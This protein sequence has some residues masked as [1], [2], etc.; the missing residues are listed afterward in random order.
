[1][2][3][4]RGPLAL[5]CLASILPAQELPFSVLKPSGPAAIRPYLPQTVPPVRL[6]NSNRLSTLLRAGKLYLTVQDAIALAV[7]NNLGLEINRYGP[8]L[9][10]SALERSQA[11]GPLRG[12]P[13]A[14][15]QV[16]SVN[17][18]V[19]VNGSAQSA[20][21]SSGGGG[22]GSGS[23]GNAAIQQVGAI[24]PN[25]DPVL[26]STTTQAHLTQPQA[27]TVLS[28]TNA[29]IQTVR[30]TNSVLQMGLLTGGTVQFRNYEQSFRENAPS[31]TLNPAVGPHMDLSIRQNLL[32]GFG[33]RLNDR[34]I[35][36][37]MINVTASRESFR[38]QLLDM[39]AAVVNQYWDVAAARN[40]LKTPRRK[41]PPAPCREWSC[42]ARRR[43]SPR[44][45]RT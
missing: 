39:V 26:Q 45:A 28:Q 33:V 27:N 31:D 40:S 38:S 19:G 17:A 7:E 18:G 1:V 9:A 44:A 41:S 37:S 35:R 12:V 21:L 2:R 16:S 43:R 10:Q 24:T 8:L 15:A 30:T 11:G 14:S 29:L 6:Y 20:G 3:S 23:S 22:G 42:P 13:S 34:S 36:I 32:Q 4:L 5:L 25:L